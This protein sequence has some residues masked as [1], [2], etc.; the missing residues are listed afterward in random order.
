MEL[1]MIN[2]AI[3]ALMKYPAVATFSPQFLKR[4]QYFEHAAMESQVYVPMVAQY[5]FEDGLFFEAVENRVKVELHRVTFP[6]QG[7]PSEAEHIHRL[8]ALAKPLFS[9]ADY[10][11]PFAVGLNYQFQALDVHTLQALLPQPIQQYELR[12]IVLSR[13]DGQRTF[14]YNLGLGNPTETGDLPVFVEANVHIP[15]PEDATHALDS[16]I[17]SM[18]AMLEEVRRELTAFNPQVN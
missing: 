15:V 14:N 2:A 8:V 11:V 13:S 12:Q 5:G 17:T 6:E 18:H 9:D 3:V 7:L 4:Q 10:M 16:A 1:E